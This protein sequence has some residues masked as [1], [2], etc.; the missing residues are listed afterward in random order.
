MLKQTA[1]KPVDLEAVAITLRHLERF[2]T[3]GS[4]AT[5]RSPQFSA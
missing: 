1:V 4:D 2:W 3:H 5:S